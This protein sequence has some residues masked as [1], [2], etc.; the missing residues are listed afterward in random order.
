[1]NNI[2]IAEMSWCDVYIE[3]ILDHIIYKHN[4]KY[5]CGC[6]WASGGSVWVV[7][8]VLSL[9][10]SRLFRLSLMSP[11][12]FLSLSLSLLVLSYSLSRVCHWW[13][14]YYKSLESLS[15]ESLSQESHESLSCALWVS[16]WVSFWRVSYESLSW[17][18][19]LWIFKVSLV[20]LSWVSLLSL[21]RLLSESWVSLVCLLSES[22]I[23]H[24]TLSLDSPV[25][26]SLLTLS[27]EFFKS[28][29]SFSYELWAYMYKYIYI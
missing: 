27:Y 23:S 2:Y 18:S 17:V 25:W 7:I 21:L 6:W 10:L 3:Y 19:L 16:L 5:S 15:Y 14:F 9:F 26:H 13:V 24:M 12:W 11:E 1:M 29:E 8:D 22:W 4:Q 28:L 20:S